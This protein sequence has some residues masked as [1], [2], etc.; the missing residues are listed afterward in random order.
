M[1]CTTS[2][3][4]N[5]AT[6]LY[7][8][9]RPDL[10]AREFETAAS[11]LA[12][13]LGGEG[14]SVEAAP[15][16]LIVNGR[17][18]RKDVPGVTLIGERLLSH[19]ILSM[20]LSPHPTPQDLLALARLLAAYPGTYANWNAVLTALGPARARITLTEGQPEVVQEP[21][22]QGDIVLHSHGGMEATGFESVEDG[23]LIPPALAVDMSKTPPAL[24]PTPGPREDPQKL[25]RLLVKGRSALD[26]GDWGAMLSIAREFL[27]AENDAVTES[28]ARL[29]RVE[30]K[31]LMSRHEIAQIAKLAAVGDRRQE[32]VEVLQRLGLTATEVLMDLLVEAEAMAERRGYYS[33]LTRMSDGNEIIVHHL[34]SPLWYVVRNAADLCGEMG[35]RQAIPHL[36]DQ[37]GHPDE[38]VRKSVAG[39]L[40]QLGGREVLEPLG[41][42]LRDPSPAVRLF[43]LGRVEGSWAR[44]LAMPLANLLQAEEHPDVCREALRALGRIGTP[45]AIMALQRVAVGE[46]TQSTKRLQVQAV[47]AIGLAG[48]AGLPLLATLAGGKDREVAAAAGRV[49]QR[50]N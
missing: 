12:T 11:L 33:A 1:F 5:L 20:G 13:A 41:R 17:R 22:N 43:V 34:V 16:S 42:L 30:L 25:E 8:G 6:V 23:G 19:G 2:V 26:A 35:L 50:P 28:A 36:A 45:D 24:R 31:R 21:P 38:R 15:G 14:L 18:V 49:L 3:A 40:I 7:L 9:R 47:E 29:Y 44:G 39:A 10:A 27:D 46:L 4:A 37:V 48:K 32:A